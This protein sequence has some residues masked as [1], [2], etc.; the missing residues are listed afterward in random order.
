MNLSKSIDFLLENA[1]DV[2]KYRLHK[3]ILKD[4]SKTEE[5][6]LLEKVMQT[7][8]YKFVESYVKPNGYIGVG[9]HTGN[10]K[11][12]QLKEG[13]A[14]ARLLSSYAIP[15]DNA[16]IKNY[17]AVL[18]ND[19]ILKE[20][21]SYSSSAVRFYNNRF[22]GL[23]SGFSLMTLLYTMQAML[24]YGDDIEVRQYQEISFQA[25]ANVLKLNSISDI[26]KTNQRAVKYSYPYIEENTYCPS[27]YNLAGLAYTNNWRTPEN[28]QIMAKALNHRNAIMP[29]NNSMQV[30]IKN[31][32]Y[33]VGLLFGP[34]R[35]FNESTIDFILYRRVL[36]E[37]AMLGVG[38]KV[39]IIRKSVTNLEE[40]L[41]KDGILRWKLSTYQK[42]QLKNCNIPSAYSDIWLEDNH[43]KENAL[44]C[45]LTF[46]AVQFYSLINPTK[47]T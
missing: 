21:F 25:F 28:I 5:E 13:E 6:N 17:I 40:V 19:E 7:P 23:N 33:S 45:D 26:Q 36:T 14:A 41:S 3:E 4:I 42:Q 1:G 35:E 8:Y 9:M 27:V 34:F 32:Y 29:K 38:E 39:E 22:L 2:I 44:E 11:E 47:R 46:W 30:K 43:K 31:N 10:N 20:E 18:R 12:S 15:K 16:I 24:G 37:I